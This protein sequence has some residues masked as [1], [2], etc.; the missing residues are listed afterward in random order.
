MDASIDNVLVSHSSE[1]FSEVSRVLILDVFDDRVPAIVGDRSASK[2]GGRERKNK[3]GECSPIFVVDEVSV[4]WS[5]N[6][7]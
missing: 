2:H 6:D 4:T 1:F 5:V 3:K 7:V